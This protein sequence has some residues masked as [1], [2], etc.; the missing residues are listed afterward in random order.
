[1]RKTL[2]ILGCIAT[3]LL[4][5]CTGESSRPVATGKGAIR[6]ISTIP[7]SPRI[8]F[9]IEERTLAVA[10]YAAAT[11]R[12]NFDDLDYIFNFEAIFP[13]EPVNL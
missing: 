9:L 12:T 4:G 11:S 2:F 1:M 7:T 3:L 8:I 13:D 5:A 6:T 10:E